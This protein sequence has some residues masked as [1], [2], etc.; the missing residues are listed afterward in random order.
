MTH[1]QA[2]MQ[3]D[4][5]GR[6][7]FMAQQ[8]MLTIQGELNQA[9]EKILAPGF[10]TRAASRTDKGVHA[11]AQ[12]VKLSLAVPA[13]LTTELFNSILPPH[14]RCHAVA[15]CAPDFIPSMDQH[16]KEYRYFFTTTPDDG[17][18]PRYIASPPAPLDLTAVQA[19]VAL[20]TG[21]HDF[22]NF[23]S[24]GGTANTTIREVF[25]CELSLINPQEFFANT[26]FSAGEA[27]SCWQ[28]RIEGRGFMKH[29]V[30]HLVGA[31]W[32]VG[33]GKLSVSEF[34]QLLTGPQKEQR[35]WRKADPQGLYLVKVRYEPSSN[36]LR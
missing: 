12:V 13:Q 28:F 31:L 4:G 20:L 17:H 21:T 14:I 8:G 29:M 6:A 32:S 1:Y 16:S 34:E 19:C 33:T 26:L 3:Y 15:P 9:L 30:R 11:L 35:P 24:I 25:S 22:K 36:S 10:S 7:G 2:I 23:W 18:D 27:S 5:T